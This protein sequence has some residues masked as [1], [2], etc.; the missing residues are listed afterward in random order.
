ML[1]TLTLAAAVA[2]ALRTSSAP[3]DERK[4]QEDKKEQSIKA[5]V[6]GTLHFESGRGYFIAVKPATKTEAE[7]RVWLWISENKVLVRQLQGLNGKEVIASGKL[8]QLPEGHGAS[9]PPLGLY[10]SRFE[11]KEAP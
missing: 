10:M 5:D 6:R 8:A 2:L 3:G 4:A 11:I 7:I 1:R 9:V